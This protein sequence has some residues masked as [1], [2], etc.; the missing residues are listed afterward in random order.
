MSAAGPLARSAGDLR[1]ALAATGGPEAP[2]SGAYSWALPKSRHNRLADFRVGVVFDDERAP[3][4]SEVGSLLTSAVDALGR[5]GASIRQG[6]PDG[7]DPAQDAESF[8]F[9][10]GLFFAYGEQDG[11]YAA[12]S[13]VF[14]QEQRRMAARAAWEHYFSEVDVFLC[15][16]N[17]TPAPPHDTRA[18]AERMIQTPEGERR[19]DSQP[20]WIS[21]ASLPGLPAVVAP[22]GRTPG[23]LPV[24]IQIVGPLFEDN[25]AIT[26][27]ELLADVAGGYEP[28]RQRPGWGEFSRGSHRCS[29]DNSPQLRWSPNTPYSKE[30]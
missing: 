11:E 10:I 24:G 8:G 4:S 22:I 18:F 7:I 3:V 27:A 6:W 13:A 9:H 26:F 17:F 12:L 23:G 5:A 19:Y 21:H 29:R 30:C 15:P 28:P 25:T 1:I 14:E 20:F 16:A 2:A